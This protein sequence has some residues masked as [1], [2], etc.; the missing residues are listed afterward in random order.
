MPRKKKS[1]KAELAEHE[2]YRR[3]CK[4]RIRPS[5]TLCSI[6]IG[7]YAILVWKKPASWLGGLPLIVLPI[8]FTYM[9][10][11]A[12]VY[13]D[14]ALKNLRSDEALEDTNQSDKL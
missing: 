6:A 11:S 10:I 13:H 9:E 5:L 12:F 2:K 8:I 7:L 1:L 14:R 4:V 3:Q